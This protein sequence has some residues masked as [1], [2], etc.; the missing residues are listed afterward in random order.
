MPDCPECGAVMVA[1]EEHSCRSTGRWSK[2]VC[3][4]CQGNQ[5]C[6]DGKHFGEKAPDVRWENVSTGVITGAAVVGWG[7]TGK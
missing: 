7:Q 5:L 1:K 3:P 4:K 2:Y 6:T